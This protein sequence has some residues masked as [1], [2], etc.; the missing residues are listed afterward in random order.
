MASKRAENFLRGLVAAQPGISRAYVEGLITEEARKE[1][2]KEAKRQEV[3]D[4]LY[5]RNMESQ[6]M[7]REKEEPEKIDKI[8]KSEVE[9]AYLSKALE[10]PDFAKEYFLGRE[11][12]KKPEKSDRDIMGAYRSLTTEEPFSAESDPKTG[13]VKIT[14]GGK[15][16]PTL[17]EAAARA[18]SIDYYNKY[19]TFPDTM[20]EEEKALAEEL[21][22]VPA[23]S[24]IRWDLLQDDHPNL[25]IQAIKDSLGR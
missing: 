5:R 16:Y 13:K 21:R 17:P 15:H 24:I 7:T 25:N 18:D 11:K 22:K 9:G 6:I 8:T 10:D 4:D 2:E 3:M 23:D 14:E 19:G 20:N 1:Q 12:E